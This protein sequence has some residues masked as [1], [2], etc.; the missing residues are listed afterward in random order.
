LR[1]FPNQRLKLVAGGYEISKNIREHL[2][3]PY[4]RELL[5]IADQ[6]TR[7]HP[8]SNPLALA[9]PDFW[10]MAGA[11]TYGWLNPRFHDHY[12]SLREALGD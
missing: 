12:I 4:I 10:K 1:F 9:P 3:R 8:G 6:I 2:Y 7:K 11:K 5:E